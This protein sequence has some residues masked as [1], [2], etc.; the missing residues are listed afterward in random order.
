MVIRVVLALA[1]NATVHP[2][3]WT[4]HRLRRRLFFRQGRTL[5][6]HLDEDPGL[7]PPARG[8]ARKPTLTVLAEVLDAAIAEPGVTGIFVRIEGDEGTHVDAAE[9]RAL[10]DRFRA[11]GKRLHVHVDHLT[12]RTLSAAAVAHELTVNP[13]GP[14]M[15]HGVGI[16]TRFYGE[17]LEQIGVKVE[18]SRRGIYKSA[19]EPFSRSAPSEAF[20]ESIR[21]VVDSVFDDLAAG[22][23]RGRGWADGRAAQV[24]A[25]G[26]Y[27]LTQAVAAGIV[28][29]QAQPEEAEEALARAELPKSKRARGLAGSKGKRPRLADLGAAPLLAPLPAPLRRRPVIAVVPI[30]GMIVDKTPRGFRSPNVAAASAVA[31]R[32]EAL[33]DAVKV[34]AVVLAIDSRG[35]SVTGSDRIWSAASRLAERKP[36][37]AW[38]RGYAASGGYYIAAAAEHIVASPFTITGS[39][40]VIAGR[41]NA[42]ALAE[43]L[44][45]HPVFFER[46]SGAGL[47]SPF[48]ELTDRERA[49]LDAEMGEA[50]DRF[51]GIV[52]NARKM[53][54]AAVEAV[55][56]GR[57]WTGRQAHEHGLVDTLGHM[58]D[59]IAKA[60]ALAGI[61]ESRRVDVV[62]TSTQSWMARARSMLGVA[63][64]GPAD[65]SALAP[66][67][68]DLLLLAAAGPVLYFAPIEGLDR[69]RSREL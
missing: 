53:T 21:A 38:L 42:V 44:G 43:R 14:A 18:V 66:G 25:E 58:G 50:Y 7:A 34:D 49:W 33:A 32:L 60:R 17:A 4:L 56:Q 64:P 67:L 5:A 39:I 37:V 23:A 41:P 48:R 30:E 1:Y 29:R 65:L 31:P 40:G 16:E 63:A 28:E 20:A 15:V 8:V 61:A 36:V 10:L 9:L 46:G 54:P 3:V 19:L 13:A 57:V 11:G 68:A 2:L 55:A 35:G 52:A 22:V 12:N 26:P 27:T 6:L 24:L 47:M 59:V 69:P 62:T 45:I 51:T